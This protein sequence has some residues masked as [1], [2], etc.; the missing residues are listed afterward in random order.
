MA[1]LRQGTEKLFSAGVK[2]IWVNGSFITDKES[3]NDIDGCWSYTA[4]MDVTMLEDDFL[5]IN[6]R[7]IVKNIYGLD[8]F[9]A[10]II[11]ADSGKPFQKFFQVNRD[12]EA[13][14]IVVVDLGD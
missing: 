2:R 12:G 14:G 10:E 3:P 4:A 9:I 7:R 5:N 11:E 6:A 1:G 13:K 8:F